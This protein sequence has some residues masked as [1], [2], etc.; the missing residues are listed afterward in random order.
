MP[1]LYGPGLSAIHHEAFGDHGDLCAPG[2]LAA[3]EPGCPVLELGAGSGA[4]TRHLVAAGHPVTATD[5]STDM[6]DLLAEAVPEARVGRL[7]LGDDGIV[8]ARAIVSVGHTLSY[9][10][11]EAMVLEVL[12]QC[13]EAL[14]PGGLL[15]LDLLDRSYGAARASLAPLHWEGDGW[16]MDVAFSLPS[17]DRFVRDISLAWT[18]PD[19]TVH[20]EHEVHANVLVDAEVAVGAL[21][22]AGLDAEV[23]PSFGVEKLPP[24]FVVLS[25]TRSTL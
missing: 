5:A 12:A 9:L 22:D 14:E 21:S 4:L 20:E 1:V 17:A 19:G 6:L 15:L 7:V 25:A 24:G 11:S 18:A 8:A 3:L 23:R 13:A 10:G 16:E 2:I